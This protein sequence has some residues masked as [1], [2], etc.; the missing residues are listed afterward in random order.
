MKQKNTSHEF[1]LYVDDLGVRNH[2]LMVTDKDIVHRMVHVLRLQQD[3]ILT[4]FNDQHALRVI[5]ATITKTAVTCTVQEKITVIKPAPSITALIPVL[6]KEALEEAIYSAVELGVTYLVLTKTAKSYPITLSPAYLQRLHTI[7]HAAQ[8]QAKQYAPI[9]LEGPVT[10]EKAVSLVP[11]TA[12]KIAALQGGGRLTDHFS[13]KSSTLVLTVGPEA[14]FTAEEKELLRTH[15][16][17]GCSLGS[18][19]LRAQQALTVLIGAVRSFT[20]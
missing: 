2:T 17:A 6:K 13:Q 14:D 19:V 15:G 1:A 16:F 3:D 7:I 11:H 4:L 9:T 8:E 10:L 18:T 5:I 20:V 12:V